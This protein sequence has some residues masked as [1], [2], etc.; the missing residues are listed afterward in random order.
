MLLL[1]FV[2]A[3]TFAAG[4]LLAAQST[5]PAL[6]LEDSVILQETADVFVA[7]PV[8]MFLGD[9]GSFFVIDG[10]SNSVLRFGSSGRHVRTYG[11]RG[12]GPGEFSYIGVAGFGSDV[13]GVVDGQ[14]PRQEIEFFDLTSGEHLGMAESSGF[15]S[16][17]SARGRNLWVG[18]ID[19][20]GWKALAV[21]PLKAL[22]GGGS[23]SG[24]RRSS[25]VLDRVQVPRPYVVN[26]M[27]R[28]MSGSVRLHV[29]DDDLLVGFMAS[30]FVL[31]VSPAGE[32]LDTI[33][34]LAGSRRRT[35]DED[36]FIEMMQPGERSYEELFRVGSALVNLSRSDGYVLT[37]HQDSE[38]HGQQVSGWLYASSLKE[39]GTEQCPDTPVPTSDTGRPVTAFQGSSLFVLDQRIHDDSPQRLWTVVRRFT[40]D[41]RDC[42]GLLLA[43][44]GR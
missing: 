17:M 11:R 29:E 3:A 41:P 23:G 27:I 14:P 24:S 30:P 37:V 2:L 32:V 16:A 34:L 39:D 44:A 21:T 42:R 43:E 22:P 4:P 26:E 7:Q 8:E 31:R 19:I 1:P 5:G 36:E 20:E 6:I 40:V 28:G 38:L 10:F 15:V 9:D 18:G 35:P 13:L 12:G 25:I 33:P